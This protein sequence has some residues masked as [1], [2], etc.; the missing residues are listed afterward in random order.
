VN[1][2]CFTKRWQK[3]QQIVYMNFTQFKLACIYIKECLETKEVNYFQDMNEE[4]N[5]EM[6]V[7]ELSEYKI[8]VVYIYTSR[9]PDGKCKE[10]LRKLE[11]VIKKLS[12]KG[13]QSYVG[14]VI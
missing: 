10:F 14:T 1:V 5:F 8:I 6:A 7:I 2:L 12:M 11:L 4:R 13:R 9:S 3:E